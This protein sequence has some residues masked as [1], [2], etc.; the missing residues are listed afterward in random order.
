MY[1]LSPG[2]NAPVSVFNAPLISNGLKRSQTAGREKN[3]QHLDSI[4][5]KYRIVE[6]CEPA[7]RVPD[8]VSPTYPEVIQAAAQPLDHL[9]SS[10]NGLIRNALSRLAH[11]VQGVD[12]AVPA[13]I[14]DAVD[15]HRQARH[16]TMQE[17]QRW[18]TLGAADQPRGS[19]RSD[20]ECSPTRKVEATSAYRRRRQPYTRPHPTSTTQSAVLES[21]GEALTVSPTVARLRDNAI[22]LIGPDRDRLVTGQRRRSSRRSPPWPRGRPAAPAFPPAPPTIF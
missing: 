8:Q 18:R 6:C 14:S 15:P 21:A 9:R 4:R 5:G 2:R 10:T 22:V 16:E 17:D 1:R 13:E 11:H 20:F 3:Y 19:C 7:V 12:P